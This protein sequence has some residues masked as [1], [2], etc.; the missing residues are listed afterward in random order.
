[1]ICKMKIPLI[2][3]QRQ[4]NNLTLVDGELADVRATG[5]FDFRG[6]GKNTILSCHPL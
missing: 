1:M 2:R 4:E 6:E 5:C 3:S